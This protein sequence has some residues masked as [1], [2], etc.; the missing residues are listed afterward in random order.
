MKK[1]RKLI[2][3]CMLVALFLTGF[4][5][6]ANMHHKV[7]TNEGHQEFYD[8]LY[9]KPAEEDSAIKEVPLEDI[10]VEEDVVGEPII[11][12]INIEEPIKEPSEAKIQTIRK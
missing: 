7:D 12:D 3:G 2:L 8:E 10:V 4:S 5:L 1:S 9:S 11:E 6:G